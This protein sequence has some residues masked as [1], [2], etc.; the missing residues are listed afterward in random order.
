[1]GAQVHS[2]HSP[3]R[4]SQHTLTRR[5]AGARGGGGLRHRAG[6]GQGCAQ[7]VL[8]REVRAIMPRACSSKTHSQRLPL[9]A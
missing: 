4:G 9:A 8:P 3:P 2:S 6:L 5:R 7:G 1:V